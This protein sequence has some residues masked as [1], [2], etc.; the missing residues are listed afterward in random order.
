MKTILPL[1][2]LFIILS[3]NITAQTVEPSASVEKN[4]LQIE[5]ESLYSIQK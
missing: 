3:S 2:L 5:L 1:T 4:I